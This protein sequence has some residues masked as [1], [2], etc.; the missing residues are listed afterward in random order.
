MERMN[1]DRV[2]R[3]LIG[4]AWL[5]FVCSAVCAALGFT[6]ARLIPAQYT[7]SMTMYV[8]AG[9]DAL[10]GHKAGDLSL[11]QRLMDSCMVVMRSRSV[12]EE[13]AQDSHLG[14]T[15]DEVRSMTRFVP[16]Q[17]TEFFTVSVTGQDP[18]DVRAIADAFGAVLPEEVMRIYADGTVKVL[19]DAATPAQPSFPDQKSFALL[20]F[21]AGFVLSV[22]GVLLAGRFQR[23]LREPQELEQQFELELVAVVE[24][25][26]ASKTDSHGMEQ[27]GRERR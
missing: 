16:V 6:A 19:E 9:A 18:Q 12:M 24:N 25:P 5:I 15:A 20:G 1:L 23:F 11:S 8:A 7:A 13:V 2:V 21:V 3:L 14:Y 26:P 4:K 17:D 27:S 10:E 22:L